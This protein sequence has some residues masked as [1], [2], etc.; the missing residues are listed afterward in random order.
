MFVC[1]LFLCEVDWLTVPLC[2]VE[3]IITY[4][5]LALNGWEILFTL[6]SYNAI[7]T[8]VMVLISFDRIRNKN[9]ALLVA[10]SSNMY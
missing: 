7:D 9:V 1:L 6:R 2:C 3:G 8:S 4:L 5:Q 10:Q